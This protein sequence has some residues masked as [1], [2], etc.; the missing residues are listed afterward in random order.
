MTEDSNASEAEPASR[1]AKDEIPRLHSH[2][3]VA[4]CRRYFFELEPRFASWRPHWERLERIVCDQLSK[5][6]AW[7]L[8]GTSPSFISSSIQSRFSCLP[9]APHVIAALLSA[10]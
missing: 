9:S 2:A 4:T 8:F 10:S 1:P 7:A 6:G 5:P 3:I